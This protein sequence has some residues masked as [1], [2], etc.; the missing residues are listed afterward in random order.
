MQIYQENVAQYLNI[1]EQTMGL[2][3]VVFEA[4]PGNESMMQE[5][6]LLYYLAKCLE[7]P[8][9]KLRVVEKNDFFLVRS[10]EVDVHRRPPTEPLAMVKFTVE[11]AQDNESVE[12]LL[13]NARIAINDGSSLLFD[14]SPSYLGIHLGHSGLMTRTRLADMTLMLKQGR[15]LHDQDF[16]VSLLRA[17]NDPYVFMVL[18]QDLSTGQE[19]ALVLHETDV[20]QLTEGDQG[21]LEDPEPIELAKLII[22]SLELVRKDG[23]TYLTCEQK[24]FFN[25]LWSDM[26]ISTASRAKQSVPRA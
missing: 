1:R 16:I 25:S 24:V 12:R 15:R 4:N 13:L 7:V 21:L 6:I 14:L 8:K 3:S 17:K 10:E 23:V 11:I 22:E 9:E 18:C 20:F 26:M 19:Y 2:V 5:S